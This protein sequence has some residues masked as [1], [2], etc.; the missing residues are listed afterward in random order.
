M[1]KQFK[2]NNVVKNPL[3][4]LLP[5]VSL[6]GGKVVVKWDPSQIYRQITVFNHVKEWFKF[7]IMWF[8]CNRLQVPINCND[9][10]S[11]ILWIFSTVQNKIKKIWIVVKHFKFTKYILLYTW[12]IYYVQWMQICN[13]WIYTNVYSTGIRTPFYSC[14]DILISVMPQS[15]IL[16]PVMW[17]WP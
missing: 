4:A 12:E 13:K 14:K 8:L 7:C 11:Q 5:A 1:S 17:N 3:S 15:C 9:L 10:C 16:N 2:A 6:N